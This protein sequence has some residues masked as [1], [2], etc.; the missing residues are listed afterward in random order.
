MIPDDE[1][2]GRRWISRAGVVGFGLLSLLYFTSAALCFSAVIKPQNGQDGHATG[3]IL[4]GAGGLTSYGFASSVARLRRLR[5]P[6]IR[7]STSG[8]NIQLLGR[9]S[10]DYVPWVPWLLRVIWW[11][12]SLEMFR[13]EMIHIPWASLRFAEIR[14][15]LLLRWIVLGF[16]QVNDALG[17]PGV[18]LH[19]SGEIAI[20]QTSLATRVDVCAAAIQFRLEAFQGG[21]SFQTIKP[22][23]TN[24]AI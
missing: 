1:Y 11:I 16:E 5:Q 13:V 3:A 2:Y 19:G 21:E 8:V 10:L 20:E 24:L 17:L 12:V 6:I 18:D 14:E 22:N 4:L 23:S 7:L 15:N 9:S